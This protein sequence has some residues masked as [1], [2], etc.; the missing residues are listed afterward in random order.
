MHAHNVVHFAIHADDVERAKVFY[1]QVFQWQFEEWGPPDFYLIRT[2][3]EADRGIRGALQQRS[4]PVSGTGVIGY[5]CSIT[6]A[7]VQA[8]AA[9]IEQ[10]G[11][12]ILVK[13]VEIPT[14]GRIVTFADTEGNRAC[15]IQY[16]EGVS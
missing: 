4:E 1:E 16:E 2:G 11:G 10:H 9:A 15:A 3:T 14:V 6:V 7:D 5:E 8:C 13:E 12:R